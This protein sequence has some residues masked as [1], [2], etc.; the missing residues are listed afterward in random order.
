MEKSCLACGTKIIGRS[1]KKFCSDGCRNSYNNELNKDITNLI[2]NTNNALRKNYRVLCKLNPE[3]KT[4]T[5]K[6][7]LLNEG[8]RFD[9]FTSTYI[10]K[11]GKTYFFVY[12]YGY[13]PLEKD[14]YVLVKQKR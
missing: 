4:K 7:K 3:G 6:N 9:L 10:T 1:D 2:R 14:Y 5:T 13:L 8:F 11:E 12:D